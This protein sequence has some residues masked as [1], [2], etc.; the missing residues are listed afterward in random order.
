M[1]EVQRLTSTVD[2]L[3]AREQRLSQTTLV[4]S[5]CGRLRSLVLRFGFLTGTMT[6]MRSTPGGKELGA[7]RSG[8]GPLAGVS[9]ACVAMAVA[10]PGEGE[11]RGNML[12][13][14]GE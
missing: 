6:G 1:D 4:D 2:A 5:Q 7:G 9:A 14:C 3:T 10:A 11:R 12:S 8:D 13:M